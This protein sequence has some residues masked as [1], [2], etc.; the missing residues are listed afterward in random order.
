[1]GSR[2]APLAVSGVRHQLGSASVARDLDVL[3]NLSMPGPCDQLRQ[4]G[5]AVNLV[6]EGSIWSPLLVEMV[7]W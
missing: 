3:H 4:F 6:A 5:V 7:K 1:M 2:A